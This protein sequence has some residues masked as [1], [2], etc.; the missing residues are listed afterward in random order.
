M[1][2]LH[3][4]TE[5]GAGA[6]RGL[7]TLAVSLPKADI[8]EQ[9]VN[10][11][12]KTLFAL[13]CAPNLNTVLNEPLDNERRFVGDTSDSVK[14]KYKQDIEL[15]LAGKLFDRLNFVTI[16]GTDL[17]T[18]YAVL[19]FFVNDRPAHLIRKAVTGF[20]LHWDIRFVVGVIVYLFVRRYAV[21]TANSV[22][23]H[24]DFL[25]HNHS[26]EIAKERRANTTYT[27]DKNSKKYN[28]RFITEHFGKD[29]NERVE[30]FIKDAY[31]ARKSI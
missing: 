22:V 24:Y 16:F 15:A 12:I 6:D 5:A 11:V 18:G 26:G 2:F 28:K 8:V 14:H 4:L 20:A 17:M 7:F 30:Q 19:L 21:Q 25:Y 9:L 23:L 3:H 29:E 10:M 27:F 1:S 13:L 31:S